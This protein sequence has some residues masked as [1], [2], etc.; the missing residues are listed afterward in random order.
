VATFCSVFL[1]RLV[2]P[3]QFF[4]TMTPGDTTAGLKWV[5]QLSSW[6]EQ[7][8]GPHNS[9]HVSGKRIIAPILLSSRL[10]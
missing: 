1:G 9:A 3:V 4:Y 7:R 10:V 2:D 5:E 6:P 8:K